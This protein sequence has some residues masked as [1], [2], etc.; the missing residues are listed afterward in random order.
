MN[1]IREK[2]VDENLILTDYE[3]DSAFHKLEKNFK[4]HLSITDLIR[5]CNWDVLERRL[6]KKRNPMRK[7]IK[8][9]L[10]DQRQK[11]LKELRQP[12][13]D[14]RL[15]IHHACEVGRSIKRGTLKLLVEAY[16]ESVVYQDRE[17]A[18]PLH[19]MLNGRAMKNTVAFVLIK[20][21]PEV[22]LKRDN[23]GRTS[24]FHLVMCHL[25]AYNNDDDFP[26]FKLIPILES[27]FANT[28]VVETLLMSCGPTTQYENP[29]Y[30]SNSGPQHTFPNI[31]RAPVELR[32]PLYLMWHYAIRASTGHWKSSRKRKL[33]RKKVEVAMLFLR[34]A[35]LYRVNGS[36]DFKGVQKRKMLRKFM[37]PEKT[38]GTD[39]DSD[40][41]TELP[42]FDTIRSNAIGRQREGGA[43]TT[44]RSLGS[45]D[46][47]E[48][49]KL[50]THN[51]MQNLSRGAILSDDENFDKYNSNTSDDDGTRNFTLRS[52][53]TDYSSVNGFHG[54]TLYSEW[55]SRKTNDFVSH[56]EWSSRK[57]NDFVSPPSS[58]NDFSPINSS[59]KRIEDSDSKMTLMPEK[60][61]QLEM[62]HVRTAAYSDEEFSLPVQN[63]VD[64]IEG[65]KNAQARANSDSILR[66]RNKTQV[67]T[68]SVDSSLL[69]AKKV[70]RGRHSSRRKIEQK[71][72]QS[73][74]DDSDD[75]S[76]KRS[77]SQRSPTR[78]E[79]FKQRME[80][81]ARKK[82]IANVNVQAKPDEKPRTKFR[83]I[84]ATITFHKWLPCIAMLDKM[85]E[86]N[87][88]SLMKREMTTGYIPLHLAIIHGTSVEVIRR[89]L[90]TNKD[91]ARIRTLEMQLPLHLAITYG[92]HSEIIKCLL[93]AYP[94]ANKYRDPKTGLYPF[95]MS[96]C[97][98]SKTEAKREYI[99]DQDVP[100]AD[101][102]GIEQRDKLDSVSTCYHLLMYNPEII[103]G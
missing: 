34:S 58:D 11:D 4:L 85:L 83:I 9:I 50:P 54:Q 38:R 87:K 88:A 70:N 80:E 6:K 37:K 48:H 3:S 72:S 96:G 39:E 30:S 103:S 60:S 86:S 62:Y 41:E 43:N 7:R 99:Y 47:S 42:L 13:T 24:L 64:Y 67:S 45:G 55:S 91:T 5:H 81:R 69:R 97:L 31:W 26:S 74:G 57:T 15:P 1:K 61:G 75:D 8:K 53:E 71:I 33:N 66:I 20:S 44:S 36:V 52:M 73:Q 51:P 95:M 56:G 101:L 102:W 21:R 35:Y 89:L 94:D 17:G 90:R 84:H 79:Q 65:M 68:K 82:A 14:G 100:A 98:L 49:E 19:V 40:L 22:L 63:H 76:V 10:D 93:N 23:F 92:C 59:R 28:K 46:F 18:T 77:Q 32:C 2:P 12:D 27:L 29:Y 16:E 78:R 25:A